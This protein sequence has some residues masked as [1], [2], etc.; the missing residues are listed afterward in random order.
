MSVFG[1]SFSYFFRSGRFYLFHFAKKQKAQKKAGLSKT[2]LERP[3]KY[4][5]AAGKP[6]P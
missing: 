4:V 6:A 3:E 2:K 1:Q 5:E